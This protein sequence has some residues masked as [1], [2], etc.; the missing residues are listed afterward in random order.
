MLSA[1]DVLE[2]RI[3]AAYGVQASINVRHYRVA[4]VTGVTLTVDDASL[5][6]ALHIGPTFKAALAQTATYRGVGVREILPG[7]PGPEDVDTTGT[8]AGI[9][10]GEPLPT[11][12]SGLISLK[13]NLTTRRG[14][15][16]FYMPFPSEGD[17]DTP[18]VPSSSYLVAL[19]NL[20]TQLKANV[21]VDN[22]TNEATLIPVVYS[23]VENTTNDIVGSVQRPTWATQRSRGGFG[24]PNSPP[25]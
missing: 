7:P 1:G 15:G 18:G 12:V 11:Q 5:A 19:N 2:M 9:R 25:F 14:R 10:L 20:A 23:R 22:G 21:T 13:T 3:V 4:Q 17:N 16:R 6:L 24:R 8:G